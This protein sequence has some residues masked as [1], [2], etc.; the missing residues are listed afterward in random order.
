MMAST[1]TSLASISKVM[2]GPRSPDP[3]HRRAPG[4]VDDD[5]DGQ[6]PEAHVHEERPVGQEEVGGAA[7][8]LLLMHEVKIPE[9]PVEHERDGPGQAIGTVLL[10]RLRSQRVEGIGHQAGGGD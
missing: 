1:S 8:L 6:G 7:P 3:R 2:D 4:A 9:D 10:Y 5:D